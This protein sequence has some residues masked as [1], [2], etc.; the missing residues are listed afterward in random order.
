LTSVERR[1]QRAQASLLQS[2]SQFA[3]NAPFSALDAAQAE[4]GVAPGRML[5]VST[6]ALAAL[7]MFVI[8]AAHGVRRDQ[9]AELDRLRA[10]G[11]RNGQSLVFVL[12]EAAWMCASGLAA[13][14]GC[15]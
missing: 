12:G 14:A 13:G 10:A 11:P 8:L 1:L 15:A 9:R 3:L 7:A 6:A 4:A 5:L 2:S